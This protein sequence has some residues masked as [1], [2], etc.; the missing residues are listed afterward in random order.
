M[1][2]RALHQ[3]LTHGIGHPYL[4]QQR[5]ERLPQRPVQQREDA[6]QEH[7]LTQLTVNIAPG[8]L[9]QDQATPERGQH[10]WPT[11]FVGTHAHQ[12]QRQPAAQPLVAHEHH[13]LLEILHRHRQ[14]ESHRIDMLQQPEGDLRLLADHCLDLA[15][16]RIPV[17]HR[18][19][20]QHTQ[21]VGAAHGHIRRH[22]RRNLPPAHRVG[23]HRE[24]LLHQRQAV[25]TALHHGRVAP[26]TWPDQ[27]RIRLTLLPAPLI[28][29]IHHGQPKHRQQLLGQL[30][31][32]RSLKHH[33]HAA[34][35]QQKQHLLMLGILGHRRRHLQPQSRSRLQITQSAIELGLRRR[36]QQRMRLQRPISGHQPVQVRKPRRLLTQ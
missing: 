25:H 5:R 35:M 17:H 18:Q 11:A 31:G 24:G 30:R 28:L 32:G 22:Q 27:P 4:G 9:L 34:I 13:C 12:H 23:P 29:D 6:Q 10:Q 16:R 8:Q 19:Q 36:Q 21:V 14:P 2:P 33:A 1:R 15:Q 26:R 7:L 20:S 3:R